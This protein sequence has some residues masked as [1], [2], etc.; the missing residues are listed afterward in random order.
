MFLGDEDCGG[1]QGVA[2]EE[3]VILEMVTMADVT[4]VVTR[5]LLLS[6]LTGFTLTV[7][8][9]GGGLPWSCLGVSCGCWWA[10]LRGFS[11]WLLRRLA[12]D[13]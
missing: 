7:E 4:V 5:L 12:S 1:G 3:G 10:G 8:L 11:W 2:M 9:T 6:K 13:W